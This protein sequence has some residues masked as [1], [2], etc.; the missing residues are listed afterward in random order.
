MSELAKETNERCG[1]RVRASSAEHGKWVSGA[2]E[3]ASEWLSTLSTLSVYFTVI[4]PNVR[5]EH[6]R[7]SLKPRIPPCFTRGDGNWIFEKQISSQPKEEEKITSSN[8]SKA[9][10]WMVET[11]FFTFPRCWVICWEERR[12]EGH[13]PRK[14]MSDWQL[15]EFKTTPKYGSSHLFHSPGAPLGRPVTDSQCTV[16]AMTMK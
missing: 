9:G 16:G 11:D 7:C 10:L 14:W 4:L 8:F 13:Q 6:D 15:D 3:R 12:R 5:R 2:S 1:A